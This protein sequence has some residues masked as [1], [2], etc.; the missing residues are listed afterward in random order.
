M[1]STCVLPLFFLVPTG[2]GGR[3]AGTEL[4]ASDGQSR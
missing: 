4:N 3:W 1:A 2:R